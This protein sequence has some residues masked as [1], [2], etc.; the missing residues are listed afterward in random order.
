MEA[1]ASTGTMLQVRFL[2]G[3]PLKGA[4]ARAKNEHSPLFAGQPFLSAKTQ[5]KTEPVCSNSARRRASCTT[6]T[7]P[8]PLAAAWGTWFGVGRA[9]ARGGGGGD[10]GGG[11]AVASPASTPRCGQQQQHQQQS[12]R[13][14]RHSYS[15]STLQAATGRYRFTDSNTA[16]DDDDEE[17]TAPEDAAGP[18]DADDAA[19]LAAIHRATTDALAEANERLERAEA[20]VLELEDEAQALKAENLEAWRRARALERQQEQQE[21][22]IRLLAA[23]AAATE[24]AALWQ[25]RFLAERQA[26]RALHEKLQQLRGNLRVAVRVRP[27]TSSPQSSCFSFPPLEGALVLKLPST[28]SSSSSSSSLSRPREFEFDAVFAPA[29]GDASEQQRR[30]FEA[31]AAPLVRS[32]VDGHSACILAYGQT[33]GGKTHTMF[34]REGEAG[35]IPRALRELFR[36][37]EQERKEEEED[38]EAA[39]QQPRSPPYR[40]HVAC[41]EVYNDTVI[42]LNSKDSSLLDVCAL[43]AGELPVGVDRVQ[44]LQWREVASAGEVESVI[45]SA[46][47]R[48]TTAATGVHAA[49]SRSHAVVT[50]RITRRQ[51]AKASGAAAVRAP[52]PAA[53]AAAT[54]TTTTLLHLVDLAG[55]ERNDRT[56]ASP[57]SSLMQESKHINR[58]LSALSDVLGALQRRSSHVPYRNSKLTL[59]LQDALCGTSKVLLVACLSPEPEAAAESLS[60]LQ[61]AARAGQVEL[62]A[63]SA[64]AGRAGTASRR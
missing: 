11:T 45:S 2:G 17:E 9:A 20:R 29:E 7:P 36:L 15:F 16:A 30:I 37:A 59:A 63:S 4:R 24:R 33:G 43:P 41:Y 8:S 64:A 32:V 42:D 27:S 5:T 51:Q 10:E 3:F 56:G 44:G 19:A 58:S 55:S 6:P 13:P 18:P 60:T 35:L 34:G 62:L 22:D 49:S 25:S 14:P 39:P 38:D 46:A 31:E 12:P 48:R 54:T 26:R 50:V 40:V 53:S 28:S 21:G 1:L 57:S 23:L 47:R 61:F 52:T